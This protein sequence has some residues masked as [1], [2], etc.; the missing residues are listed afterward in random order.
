ME[1]RFTFLQNQQSLFCQFLCNIIVIISTREQEEE[2]VTEL[3][4][5]GKINKMD[6]INSIPEGKKINNQLKYDIV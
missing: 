3:K 4:W 2:E 6:K 1:K 5:E